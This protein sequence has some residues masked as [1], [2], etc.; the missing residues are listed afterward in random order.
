M[1]HL[2]EVVI[3]NCR[4]LVENVEFFRDL[5]TDLIVRIVTSLKSEVYLTD[6][7]V[8]KAGS[9]GDFMYFIA[10]GTVVVLAQEDK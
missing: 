3:S 10:T 9:K 7:I 6:D 1:K 5:P 4:H 8:V 2:Q